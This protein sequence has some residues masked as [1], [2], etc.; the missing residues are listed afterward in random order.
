MQFL[1]QEFFRRIYSYSKG[2]NSV[3]FVFLIRSFI[4]GVFILFFIFIFYAIWR[5]MYLVLSV[6]VSLIVLGELAHYLRKSRE[7]DI[8][9]RFSDKKKN[10]HLL[11]LNKTKNNNLLKSSS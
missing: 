7:R 2:V 5:G 3:L 1:F 6:L 8:N 10:K 9:G 4:I 11:G